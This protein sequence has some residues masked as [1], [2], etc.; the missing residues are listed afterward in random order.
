MFANQIINKSF[1]SVSK[2]EYEEVDDKQNKLLEKLLN[3]NINRI[4]KQFNSGNI[5]Q[6]QEMMARMR[7]RDNPDSINTTWI[8]QMF[9]D[10]D[11]DSSINQE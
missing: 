2:I 10:C 3:E 7:E 9:K 8:G 5:I 6:K 4:N 11:S 1:K